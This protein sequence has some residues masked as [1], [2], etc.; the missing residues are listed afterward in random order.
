M[1]YHWMW[2]AF[3]AVVTGMLVLDTVVFVR[4][5]H[6]MS[7]GQSLAWSLAWVSLA[8]LFGVAVYFERGPVKGLEFVTGYVVEWSLSMDN[9]FV[10]LVIFAYFAVPEIYRQ[11]VLF[12]GI[13]LAVILRGVFIAAGAA[14]LAHFEWIMYLFG[15]FL[16]FTAFKL[17]RQGDDDQI[18][19]SRNPILRF[20]RRFV[21][22]T[23]DYHEQRFFVRLDGHWLATPLVPV[24]IVIGTT[25]IVFATDS[26][27]AIFG[28][29]RDPFIV[30]TSNVFAV[31]GLRGLFFLLAGI[32][33]LFRF[34]KI[35]ISLVLA[36]IGVKMLVADFYRIPAGAS[37]LVVGAILGISILASLAIRP[38]KEEAQPVAARS[39]GPLSDQPE[40]GDALLAKP[41]SKAEV[42]VGPGAG[43]GA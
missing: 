17:L 27:P 18:E 29:T 38:R 30:Y 1:E 13:M 7:I 25:D 10:F 26:I 2:I 19:P 3:G 21:A 22:V 15:A 35:G 24:F 9:L 31:L 14:L 41:G 23:P 11:R 28:I 34:L 36:F 12:W 6:A 32:V 37:L 5:P 33:R 39:E 20:F 8:A 4:R 40:I 43:G 42:G 16:V